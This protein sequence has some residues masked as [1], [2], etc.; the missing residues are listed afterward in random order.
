MVKAGRKENGNRSGGG[1]VGRDCVCQ[2]GKRGLYWP[3]T[4]APN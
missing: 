2:A 4:E 3:S 1:Q